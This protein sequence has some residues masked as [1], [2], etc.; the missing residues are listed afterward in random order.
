MA[1]RRRSLLLASLAL[2]LRRCRRRQEENKKQKRRSWVRKIFTEERKERGEWENLFRELSNDDQ[3]YYYR[4][5]RMSPER[6]EHL[7]NLV[8]SL[9]AK[10]D[11]NY[12]K[13]IPA[14]KHLVLTLRY[15]AE[16]C[17]QQALSLGFRVGKSTIFKILKEVCEALC[18]VL[19][20][21]Y[22][23][24]TSTEEEWKQIC[25]EFLEL[26]NM[27]HVI[28]AISGKHVAME[29]PQNTGSLYHNCK[30]FF[31]QVLLAVCDAKYK[32]IFIDVGQYGSTNDRAVLKN[33]ELGRCLESYFLNIPSKD[34][35][36]KNYFKDGEPFILPYYMVGDKIF[37]LKDY[38]LCPYP[39]TKSG[40]S[41]ARRVIDNSFGI[42]VARRRLFRKPIRADK[43]II[44]SYILAGVALH[45]YLNS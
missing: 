24:P 20:T 27:P 13:S 10:Q 44:T 41:R 36:D 29:C 16:G 34:I 6:F 21:H 11:L 12:R 18:T 31:F 5:L 39:G 14:K 15:L 38:L 4:Y 23:R 42:L 45:N 22:L 1:C 9:I 32:F 3:E 40:L 35:A 2:V 26:W 28:V 7:S 33:L 17:S 43:E 30:G 25:S 37:Q 8:G 19:A